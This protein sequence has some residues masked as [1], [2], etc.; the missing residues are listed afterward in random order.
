MA[1]PLA[2]QLRDTTWGI[3]RI[4]AAHTTPGTDATGDPATHLHLTLTDPHGDTWPIDDIIAL[5]RA[6]RTTAN[7][8]N[9]GPV[10]VHL[11]PATSEA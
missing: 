6:V 2:D 5:R 4:V 11:R 10:V 7:T 3:T 8:L 9:T 1:D